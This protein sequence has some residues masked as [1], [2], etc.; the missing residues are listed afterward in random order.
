MAQATIQVGILGLGFMGTTHLRA[1]QAAAGAG[2][3]CRI[4]AVADPV[5]NR[6]RGLPDGIGGN[7]VAVGEI[8]DRLFDPDHVKGYAEADDLF[9]DPNVHLVSICTQTP[10]HVDLATRAL[11]AGKHVLLEKP[12]A[13]TSVEAQKVADAADASGKI[14][15]PAMCMRFWPAWRWLKERIDSKEFGACRSLSLQRLGALPAWS[16]EFY[17]NPMLSGGAIVDL[18]IHDTDFVRYCFGDPA[19]VTSVGYKTGEAINR[20]TTVY[21]FASGPELVS[22]EGGWYSPGFSFRMRYVAEFEHATADFDIG[23]NPQVT[24]AADGKSEAVSLDPLNGYDYEVR[25]LLEAIRDGKSGLIASI[26][27]AVA[28]VRLLEAE[29]QSVNS[30]KTVDL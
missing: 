18:H 17:L 14:C 13:L 24:L 28:T 6:R 16:H 19:S 1:Y 23:R 2:Y 29:V 10:T 27:D 30:R 8:K 20:V 9:A 5:E 22:A 12:V 7:L 25:H 11:K 21:H 15:M 3:P 26:H 4:V